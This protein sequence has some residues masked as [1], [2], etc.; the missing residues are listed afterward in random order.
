[1]GNAAVAEALLGTEDL[2]ELY[3]LSASETEPEDD[4]DDDLEDEE[5]ED[6]EDEEDEDEEDE[7][8]EDEGAHPEGMPHP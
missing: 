5:D 2:D 8:D 7:E 3:K 6:E 4:E 1:M